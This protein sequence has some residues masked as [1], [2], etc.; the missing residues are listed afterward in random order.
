MSPHPYRTQQKFSDVDVNRVDIG[1]GCCYKERTLI[2]CSAGRNVGDADV[3][4]IRLTF[5]VKFDQGN[6]QKT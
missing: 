1:N 3:D 4:M 2:N 5:S 6:L